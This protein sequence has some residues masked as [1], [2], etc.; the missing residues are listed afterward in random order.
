MKLAILGA[1]L[2]GVTLCR[3]LKE[4]GHEITV[5]EKENKAGGLCR[6]EKRD[7]FTFDCSGSHII[8]SRDKEVLSFME[9]VL[10]DNRETRNR[11]TKIFY[12]KRYIK[13]PFE[14]G[15]YQLPKEDLYF[16][17]SEYIK[18]LIAKEKG[19]VSDPKNFKEWIY[20]AFGKGIAESYLIPYN[21]KIWNYPLDKM[22]KHWMDGRVPS[23]PVEDIIKS[24]IGIETEGYTHQAVF[25][26]PIDGGIEALIN[27]AAKPVKDCIKTNTEVTSVRKTD[28]GWQITAG[29]NVYYADKV[30]STI[31]LQILLPMLDDVPQDV[32][33]ACSALHYNSIASIE[34]GFKG[35]AP[36]ISWM[37]VPENEWGRFNRISFPSNFSKHAAPAGCSSVLAEITYNEG[38]EVSKMSDDELIN[39]AADGLRRM[40]ILNT[41][42]VHA[43]ADRFKYAYV[44]Y[45]IDY[46]KN[47]KIIRE[48]IEGKTGI[49]LVGRFSQFEYLNMDGCIRSAFNY[50]EKF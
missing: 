41:E 18:M 32:M 38:D 27:A 35:D 44:V 17:I 7:G 15:L 29:G 43:S 2:T 31:P 11:S 40:G 22:S 45:D 39:H 12:K 37:Y 33:N 10:Q 6:S 19:E 5:F 25:S 14:N 26:Y 23:P 50:A 3:L 30:I 34:I 1:G 24:A 13:Y 20:A 9:N 8:F 16:C 48:Y 42:I 4:K 21:E 36:D 28:D 49:S 47:I 46:Q